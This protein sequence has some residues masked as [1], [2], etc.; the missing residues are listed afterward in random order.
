MP[1]RSKNDYKGS[2]ENDKHNRSMLSKSDF[3]H[4]SRS[5]NVLQFTVRMIP[6]LHIKYV[7]TLIINIAK[8]GNVK[9]TKINIW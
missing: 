8:Q 2:P 1:N 9:C 7:V 6:G 3:K 4:K 5:S